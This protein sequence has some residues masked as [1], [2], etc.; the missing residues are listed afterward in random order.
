MAG[1]KKI[2]LLGIQQEKLSRIIADFQCPYN[3]DVEDFLHNKATEFSRQGLASTYLVFGSYQERIALAGYFALA[4]KYFRIKLKGNSRLNSKLR[5]R[6]RKFATYDEK[7]EKGI[8]VAPLIAQLG[9]NYGVNNGELIT[10][11]ELLKLACDT[12]RQA[13]FILGGRLTYLEC[14]DVPALV[15]FYESNGFCS[16]GKRELEKDETDKL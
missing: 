2:N 9:K 6:L 15:R 13:Q 10:G 3:A 8:I 12:V 7:I 1:Y 14:E 5:H 4:N 11:D 16:F